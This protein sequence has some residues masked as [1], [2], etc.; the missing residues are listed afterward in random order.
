MTEHTVPDTELTI[1]DRK[2]V[3]RTIKRAILVPSKHKEKPRHSDGTEH[4]V[5]VTKVSKEEMEEL[6]ER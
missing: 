6:W 1:P 3:D 2:P 5:K 4:P